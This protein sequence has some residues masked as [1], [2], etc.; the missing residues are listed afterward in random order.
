M[1]LIP[2]R[3]VSHLPAAPAP[4][5]SLGSILIVTSS[6][7]T[8]TMYAE[9]LVWRGVAVLEVK[10]A[11][12]ALA[13]LSMFTPDVVLIE[14]KLEDGR[15]VDLV[16][17]L[18]RS[19]QTSNIPIALLSGDV[20]GMTPV[21]AHRFGCDLLIPIPCLPDALFDSLVQLAGDGVAHRESGELDSWLFVRNDESVRIVRRGDFELIVS[22]PKWKR[23]VYQFRSEL[24]LSTFQAGYEQRLVNEG[25]TFEAFRADRRRVHPP[26]VQSSAAH[27]GARGEGRRHSTLA[28]VSTRV[29][30]RN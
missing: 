16:L 4:R 29:N 26:R 3:A 30:C 5:A 10:N 1:S 23:A 12:A 18:R 28:P 17:T 27:A 8:R 11:T 24:E 15:G 19:R 21:R 22:G 9:Y 20:F 6:R 2:L 13:H 25:F 7:A 14:D